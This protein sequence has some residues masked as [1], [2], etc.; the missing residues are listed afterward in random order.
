LEQSRN[1]YYSDYLNSY[2][3]YIKY[4]R[5]Y[6]YNTQISYKNDLEQ[7]GN[8]LRK[9]FDLSPD[10]LIKNDLV[11]KIS[12]DS[13][14]LADLKS[15]IAGLFEEK[16]I[17]IKKVNKFKSFSI[18]RKISVLKSFFKY[19]YK[20]NIIKKNPAGGLIFPKSGKKFPVFFSQNDI[21]GLLDKHGGTDLSIIDKAIIELFYSTGIRLS[22]L[23][24]LKYDDIDW[25]GNTIKVFG[26]GSKER[27]VPFGKKAGTALKNYSEI[28]EIC[29]INK[30]EYFFISNKGKKLYPMQVYRLI[31]KDFSSVSELKKKSPHV[32]RH[33]FATHMLDRGADIRAVKELLGHESLSTTQIYTHITAEKLKKVYKQAHPKA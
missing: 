18:S 6:S 11:F 9:T 15:F 19:F 2:L 1:K 20:Y 10:S 12:L 32:L 17:D 5:H 13:I 27:I 3:E 16:K 26:K 24:N 7:F 29:N 25:R 8:F 21:N 28:R 30:L 14:T 23:I 33:T 4:S 31:K 22:E